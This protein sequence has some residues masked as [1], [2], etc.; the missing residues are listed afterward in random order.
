MASARP[1]ETAVA[2]ALE[3]GKLAGRLASYLGDVDVGAD[4]L[5][6]AVPYV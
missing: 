6:S 4:H 1:P 5:R 2:C 3:G